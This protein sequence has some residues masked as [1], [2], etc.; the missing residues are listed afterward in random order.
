MPP[1]STKTLIDDWVCLY[2]N[3]PEAI[4]PEPDNRST[5]LVDEMVVKR[6][7]GP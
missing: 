7:Q 5:I 1:D 6:V 4:P 3:T 2:N